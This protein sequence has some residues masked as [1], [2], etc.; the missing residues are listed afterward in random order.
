MDITAELVKQL[1]DKTNCGFMDC[2]KALQE[3]QG[4]ME[5]AVTYLRQKGI[6]VATKRA[7]RATSEGAVWSYIGPD[8]KTGVL[9][10]VNCESDFVA[11]TES[12]LTFGESLAAQIAQTAPA[13][14]EALLTQPWQSQNGVTVQEH[15]TEIIGQIGEN[16]RVRR[17]NRFA[18]GGP[19]AAYIHFGA[20][21]GVLLE[22]QASSASP[23]LQTLAKDLAM[24]VA[25]TN[26]LAIAPDQ[27]DPEAVAKEK[28]IYEAQARESGKPEN[29]IERM[30]SGR[31]EKF[32]KE[33]CLMGQPFVKNPDITVAQ[34][35]RETG[36]AS[37]GEVQVARFVR[38]QIGA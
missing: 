8:A 15:L 25:A 23:E 14:L 20:K 5:A 36:A 29:I 22:L 19:V 30:V 10:E 21:I 28:A 12:F 11:K 3:T 32:F 1:R 16:I 9:L 26:P 38:Y 6:A 35:L 31:L 37:G 27:L 2:K 18:D 24:Q 7:E 13:D 34:L 17:F 4:D 33:V